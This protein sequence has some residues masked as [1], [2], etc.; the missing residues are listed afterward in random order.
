[1][2]KNF[3][4]TCGLILCLSIVSSPAASQTG[5]TQLQARSEDALVNG[6]PSQAA[7]LAQEMLVLDPDN[8]AGIFLLAL[9]QSDL[10]DQQQA[11]ATAGRAY[12]AAP[13]E[14]TRFQAARLVASA[15]FRDQQYARAELWLRRAANHAQTEDEAEA[16]VR[17][18]VRAAGANPLSLQFTASVAPSDNINNGSQDGVLTFEGIDLIFLLPENRLALSGIEYSG[19][20]RIN[21]RL[22]ADDQQTTTLNTFVSGQT[23]SLSSESQDLLASSPNEA[24]QSVV[25]SDFSSAI[26]EIGLTR[27]QLQLSSLGPTTFTVNL[28]TYWQGGEQLLNY[29]DLILEQTMPAGEYATLSFRGSIRDQQALDVSLIDSK[30]YDLT[31]AYNTGLANNDQLQLSLALRQNNAGF[32]STYSE[33]RGG[34]GYAFAKPVLNTRW[35]TSLELGYRNYDEFS[36]TLDG[37]RDRFARLQADTV[38]EGITYFGFSPSMS[39]RATRTLSSA[40]EFTSSALEVRFGVQSNF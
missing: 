31:G 38:F 37:R 39:F 29:Q 10:G 23:Y 21:Y 4:R 1:M 26:A 30:I 13:T 19:S 14:E 22:S 32:E 25:G 18:Y 36:T 9:A 2:T 12:K 11:A 28:G 40:E 7:K 17:E 6:D 20:A 33:Y 34:I 16:V 27:R 3:F 15:R 35:S 8:F 24:V 5:F